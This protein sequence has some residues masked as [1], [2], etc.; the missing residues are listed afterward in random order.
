MSEAKILPITKNWNEGERDWSYVKDASKDIEAWETSTYK[1]LPESYRRFMTKFNGGRIYP[2]LLRHNV[3]NYSSPTVLEYFYD[4][5]T[6]MSHFNRDVYGEGSPPDCLII[7]GDPGG[8][9]V[10]LSCREQDAGQVFCWF[11]TRNIW[12]TDG[13]T[14]IWHQANS[15]EEL[16]ASLHDDEDRN[17]YDHWYIPLCD[18]LARPLEF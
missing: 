5:D 3:P 4:W 14:E 18:T 7:G 9:E 17:S 16:L 8:L 15:F 2:S 1:K 13:N 11:H 6:V 10:L 12:G